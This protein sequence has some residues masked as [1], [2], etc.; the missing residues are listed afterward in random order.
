MQG[1]ITYVLILSFI[2][3]CICIRVKYVT[4]N[5]TY[6]VMQ[7][8]AIG[9]GKS[10]DTQAFSRA[11]NSACNAGGMST[12]VIPSEKSFFVTKVNFSGPCDSKILIQFEGKIVAPCKQEWRGESYL[13]T[14]EY[15][16]GLTIDG[17]GLGE[18]DGNGSTWWDCPNCDRPGLFH[19]H[20]CNN[21]TVS[22]LTISNSPRAHVSANKCNGATFSNISIDSPAHSPN[23]DGFDISASTNISIQD[24][25]IKA[26][27]DCIAING[28][29]YFVNVTRITCGPGHGI[30]VGSLGKHN[31][32]DQ[33]SDIY[34]W[35]C[36][37]TGSTNGARIKTVPGGS[38]YAK[39]I[40]YEQI[41][42]ENV[43]NP[44]IIDQDYRDL[45]ETPSVLVS[46]V[47]YR[48]FKGTFVNKVAIKLDCSS[49]GCLDILLDQNNIV[50][51]EEGGKTFVFCRNAHGTARD[52]IP[53]VN[54]L[55]E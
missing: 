11:W 17:N 49:S 2:S 3:P 13:I 30:S 34:V 28:G 6:N 7:Y 46:S 41:I 22:N 4:E 24:S 27:D 43:T 32:N 42:L 21:L 19:F 33:V 35:N 38:G 44:I 9:D 10:D 31:A 26:G 20:S 14:I 16:N 8:G 18:V 5:N 25:N 51:A 50:S 29:S 1:F 39:N 36:T 52:T 55:S 53:Q 12:L 40:T 15:L 54:C 47:T 23:T 37:F 45:E 48:G